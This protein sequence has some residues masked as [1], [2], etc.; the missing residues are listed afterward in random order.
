MLSG[1]T[2]SPVAASNDGTG[3]NDTAPAVVIRPIAP[4]RFANTSAPVASGR[5]YCGCVPFGQDPDHV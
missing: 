4:D 3:V 1:A 5:M 2:A